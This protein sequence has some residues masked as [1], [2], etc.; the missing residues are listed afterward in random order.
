[1]GPCWR[2]C[3]VMGYSWWRLAFIFLPAAIRGD[4]GQLSLYVPFIFGYFVRNVTKELCK[5]PKKRALWRWAYIPT[6]WIPAMVQLCAFLFGC[7]KWNQD[8]KSLPNFFISS[9]VSPMLRFWF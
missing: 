5:K 4:L 9:F 3:A 6:G 7:W 8:T 1:M 2:D